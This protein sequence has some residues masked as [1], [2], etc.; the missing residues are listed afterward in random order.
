MARTPD[1]ERRQELLDRIVE[2]LS[3]HG[4]AHAT[5]RPMARELDVSINRLVHHFGSKEELLSAAMERAIEQQIEVLEAWLARN[6]RLT[7]IE[8]FRKWWRW[9]N[10]SPTNLA[11]VRLNYEA[12]ALDPS[13]TGLTGQV[14]ADQI[15]VWRQAVE[16]RFVAEGL[17]PE[18]A[19]LEASLAKATFTGLAMDLFA[20]GDRVRLNRSFQEFVARLRVRL[21]ECLA[22]R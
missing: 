6:P 5:L 7:Q 19:A 14:R 17:N 4:L 8:V 3:V 2:Y 11:L 13:V 10:E 15:G 21:D 1:L 22:A 16:Q 12:A 20:T 18:Q 9:M